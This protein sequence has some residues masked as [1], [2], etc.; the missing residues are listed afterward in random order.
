MKGRWVDILKIKERYRNNRKTKNKD[1]EKI[2]C[3]VESSLKF[4]GNF[5]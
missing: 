1:K 2:S 3:F 4:T 5:R